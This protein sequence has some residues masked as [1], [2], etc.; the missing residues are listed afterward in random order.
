MRQEDARA[1][2]D[3]VDDTRMKLADVAESPPWRHAAFGAVMAALVFSVSLPILFQGAVTAVAMAG[4]AV[5]AQGDR[6]RKGAFVNGWRVGKTLWVVL[7]ILAVIL[8]MMMLSVST[9]G[10]PAPAPLAVLA[11][12]GSFVG[13][14]V[15][16]VIWKRVFRAE[17]RGSARL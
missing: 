15:G 3:A 13:A 14:S 16:S 4:V 8:G 10:E 1:A 12:G 17:M 6:R 5:L 2:L 11:A 9:R 7:L